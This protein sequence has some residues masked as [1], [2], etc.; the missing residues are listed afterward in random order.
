MIQAIKYELKPNKTQQKQIKMFCGSCRFVYNIMLERKIAAYKTDKTVL[1]EFDLINQLIPLKE[2]Y[3][4][5]KDCPSQSLQQAIHNLN[6][7]YIR[8]FKQGNGFPKFKK[9]G[10]K[11]SFKIPRI[12]KIDFNKWTVN[13]AK[14]GS[15]KIYKGNN[16]Q[17]KGIIKSYTVSYYSNTDRYYISIIYETCNKSKLN[18]GK[19]VGIDLGVKDFA[20]LSDGTVFGNPKYFKSNL[21]KVQTLQKAISRKFKKDKPFEEQSNSYKKL[22][23]RYA[24]LQEHIAFQRKDY[25]HKVSSKISNNYST[26]CVETLAIKKMLK[27]PYLAQAISDCGWGMFISMLENKCDKLIK[28]DKYFASSQLCSVCGYKNVEVKDLNLRKWTCPQ[29]GTTHLRDLNAAKNIEREGLSLCEHK[30]SKN[31]CS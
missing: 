22:I 7:A 12:C 2:E 18:N 16:K 28:I 25:L 9:K 1:S 23:K 20:V 14:L 31:V 19:C 6:Q 26:V 3:S 24:K 4:F 11:D 29:C 27:N 17:I 10:Y 15:T 5:L 30:T 21:K 8:F 13:I